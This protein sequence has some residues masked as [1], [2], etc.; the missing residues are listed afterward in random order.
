MV[1][2]EVSRRFPSTASHHSV[3]TKWLV[4]YAAVDKFGDLHS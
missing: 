2:Q 4:G 3:G 1:V